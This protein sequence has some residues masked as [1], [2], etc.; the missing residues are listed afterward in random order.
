MNKKV[1]AVGALAVLCAGVVGGGFYADSQLKQAY[2][3][4]EAM[5]KRVKM[6]VKDYNVGLM[7]G[8]ASWQQELTPD[9]CNPNFKIHLRGE[10]T[11][12]RGLFGYH[13]DSKLYLVL[14]KDSGST[15]IFLADVNSRVGLMGSIDSDWIVPAGEH[16]LGNGKI[17]WAKSQ[18]F[19][20]I[21]RED[22]HFVLDSG[23][24]DLPEFEVSDGMRGVKVS[25]V[26]YQSD[27]GLGA[28]RMRSGT[29]KL[30]IGQLAVNGQEFVL[31]NMSVSATQKVGGKIS[32]DSAIKLDSIVVGGNQLQD[33]QINYALKEATLNQDALNSL[34]T[35]TLAQS[36]R[37]VQAHEMMAEVEKLALQ[38]VQAGFTLESKGNQAKLNGAS[39]NAQAQFTVP[40]G[41]YASLDDFAKRVPSI[42]KYQARAEVDKAFI[43]EAVKAMAQS[44]GRVASDEEIAQITQQ[45]IAT[46][47]AKEEGGKLIMESQQ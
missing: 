8:K 3:G 33:I 44:K 34:K 40:A 28:M 45:F 36:E 38:L 2:Y 42:V 14:P 37:C 19:T 22:G 26:K 13:V 18:L 16:Q 35:L 11:I 29:D 23:K 12:R 21:S 41:D 9:L 5:D 1:M 25:Q 39:V 30:S 46:T 31:N 20:Q 32:L 10:D 7:S 17:K 6:Q 15:E 27:A 4:I 47:Q 43:A 24:L